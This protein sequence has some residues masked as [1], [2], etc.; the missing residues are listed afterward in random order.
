MT[1]K[2]QWLAFLLLISF[3]CQ[4]QT[5]LRVLN[6]DSWS[7]DQG[8]IE[9]A[10]FTL[11]PK[12]I[13][14]EV[15]MYLTFSARGAEIVIDSANANVESVLRF[16]LPIG[17]MV[18]DSWLWINDDIIQA[19]IE[20]RWSATRTY[21][22]IVGFRLDPSLLTKDNWSYGADIEPDKYSLRVFP[23]Q[24]DSTRRVK[25]TYL[26]P[27]NWSKGKVSIPL[28]TDILKAS[29]LPVENITI[30]CFLNN[31]FTNP[32]IQQLPNYTF[33]NATHAT[34]GNHLEL[35]LSNDDI[36][37][38]LDVS[39]DVPMQNGVFLSNYQQG[40]IDYYQLAIL[41][42][43]VLLEGVAPPK[44]VAV[45]IDYDSTTTTFSKEHVLATLEAQLIAN[46][47]PNDF[48]NLIFKTPNGIERINSDWLRADEQRIRIV[49]NLLEEA[50]VFADVTHLPELLKEGIEY[51]QTNGNEG[52]LL[53]L[54]CS[55]GFFEQ[56]IA[57]E[58]MSSITTQLSEVPISLH[59]A[60]YQNNNQSYDY[61]YLGLNAEGFYDEYKY[62]GNEYFY[63]LLDEQTD[64]YIHVIREQKNLS[65]LLQKSLMA[66][67]PIQA[68]ESIIIS[69]N[70]GACFSEFS[71][72]QSNF[73]SPTIAQLEVGKCSGTLPFTIEISGKID[74]Q[75][76]RK[77]IS[78]NEEFVNEGTENHVISWFGNFIYELEQNRLYEGLT[79]RIME[80]IIELSIEHRVL[81][82]FT[83]FLALEPEL[84]G[85]VCEECVDETNLEQA[86]SDG[87]AMPDNPSVNEVELPL[88]SFG[89][90]R[91]GPYIPPLGDSIIT[92]TQDFS[93]AET[94]DIVAI[95]NPFRAGT[96][97]SIQFNE[98]IPSKEIMVTI[99]DLQGQAVKALNP[100]Q[101]N[102][103]ATIQVF[104]DG[105]NWQQQRL[106]SGLYI[107]NIQTAGLQLNY[108][109]VLI[110]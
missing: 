89:D 13:Y 41:P 64:G 38:G 36:E 85:Y 19:D 37:N 44:K 43:E 72:P 71:I 14:I 17:S 84:G 39:F 50:Y 110:E 81:S 102:E 32:T 106:P 12:G 15:G 16:E 87:L 2:N 91:G 21:Q 22:E 6:P 83:A 88:L 31:N 61:I 60:D 34:L 33:T 56:D 96:N 55:D 10:Q 100:I 66:I 23:L 99:F 86:V 90:T 30:Q 28:P 46:L 26:V 67:S 77:T 7:S 24:A 3:F 79:Q 20:E 93:L 9:Q 47:R 82:L 104:W 59:I 53:L 97:I 4:A 95:P 45:L 70:P 52:E 1:L 11:Q 40:E 101:S 76:V 75:I 42:E 107:L 109:L 49:F 69:K 98:T 78:I 27:G 29:K 65:T 108:K 58:F 8:T 74:D 105:T 103:D 68:V 35:L 94:I 48:F 51:I 5:R 62:Y 57:K 73:N 63:N 54:S 18:T 25:I 80:K 92:A